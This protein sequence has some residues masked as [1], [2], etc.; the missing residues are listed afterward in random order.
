MKVLNPL[1]GFLL[2]SAM[3]MFLLAFCIGKLHIDIERERGEIIK[4]E[5]FDKEIVFFNNDFDDYMDM[6][7][8]IRIEGYNRNDYIKRV[9]IDVSQAP[10]RSPIIENHLNDR[11]NF[12]DEAGINEMIT[13]NTGSRHLE[14]DR[15]HY[16]VFYEVDSG[17]QILS[18]YFL[19]V[20]RF[21]ES[22]YF[23]AFADKYRDVSYSIYDNK[24]R[25]IA[26]NSNDK[27]DSY[28][29]VKYETVYGFNI[30]KYI[31]NIEHEDIEMLVL[32]IVVL[33]LFELIVIGIIIRKFYRLYKMDKLSQQMETT[34]NAYIMTLEKKNKDFNRL[35]EELNGHK[36]IIRKQREEIQGII[37]HSLKSDIRYFDA[38]TYATLG[39][40]TFGM[41]KSNYLPLKNISENLEYI[42][43][44]LNNLEDRFV[45]RSLSE[46]YFEMLK[47]SYSEA[48]DHIK[49]NNE[50]GLNNIDKYKDLVLDF[51][52]KRI[53]RIDLYDFLN[54]VITNYDISALRENVRVD[55][56]AARGYALKTYPSLLSRLVITLLN[57]IIEH[58][59]T[60]T[61]QNNIWIAIH[62]TK[63]VIVITV[64]DDGDRVSDMKEKLSVDDLEEWYHFHDALYDLVK[65]HL[66]GTL[67][68]ENRKLQGT[69]Y[70]IK[71]PR[72]LLKRS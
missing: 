40:M 45:N 25:V 61:R 31:E 47:I 56:K 32:V 53:R 46:S 5:A 54:H 9:K 41:I 19:S 11:I 70:S 72:N 20:D 36:E 21:V 60:G 16:R 43:K 4:R 62:D 22:P 26:D 29:L 14:I 44:Y 48:L 27:V 23:G 24:H 13:L 66:K 50:I 58:S 12:D 3:I 38:E 57:G 49:E 17:N 33:G 7:I 55:I 51:E 28:E 8:K 1:L 64:L 68:I 71:L 63:E 59:F 30:E 69:E 2:L 52:H 34:T 10:L 42:Q 15:I 67:D 18:I 65:V 39:K 37:G 6:F 35:E